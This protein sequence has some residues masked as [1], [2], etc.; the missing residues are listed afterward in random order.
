MWLPGP[1]GRGG[2]GDQ[3]RAGLLGAAES[4]ESK[5]ALVPDIIKMYFI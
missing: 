5:S 2:L 1:G 3:R 4:H